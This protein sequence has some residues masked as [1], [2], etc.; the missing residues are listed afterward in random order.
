MASFQTYRHSRRRFGVGS[1][2]RRIIS[3]NETNLL[4]HPD[5]QTIPPQRLANKAGKINGVLPTDTEKGI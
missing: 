2:N 3:R 1:V 5:E 4:H